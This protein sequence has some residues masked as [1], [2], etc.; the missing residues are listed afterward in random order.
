M[1][2]IAAVV[3]FS[4]FVMGCGT[5]FAGEV[6]RLALW[7]EMD[8]WLAGEGQGFIVPTV[9]TTDWVGFVSEGNRLRGLDTGHSFRY[10][11]DR[12]GSFYLGVILVDDPDGIESLKVTCKGREIGTIYGTD[13]NG[14]ALYSFS[15]VLKVKPGDALDF[16]CLTPVGCYRIYDLVFAKQ[17]IIPPLP[18][19]KFIET[20]C[21]EPGSVDVCWTTTGIVKTG[22]I[23]YQS[24]GSTSQSA[25]SQ[26]EGRNHRIRLVGLDPTA[27]Y[28]G[29]IV[30]MLR[31]EELASQPFTFRATPKKPASSQAFAIDLAIEEPTDTKRHAWPVTIGMPFSRGKLAQAA[32]LS[33][34]DPQGKRVPLQAST[35][36]IWDDGSVKWTTLDF[37]A[38]SGRLGAYR[39]ETQSGGTTETTDSNRL[40]TIK[41]SPEEW[42]LSTGA[43]SFTIA[44]KG[45][46]F[47]GRYGFD[48]NRDGMIG[49]AEVTTGSAESG[50]AIETGEGQVLY[51]AAPKVVDVREN[52][53]IRAVVECAGVMRGPN[54]GLGWHYLFRLTFWQGMPGMAVNVTLWN[55]DAEPQFRKIRR[56]SVNVPVAGGPNLRGAFQG[57]TLV[58]VPEGESMR[59][60]Q[61]QDN[62]YTRSCGTELEEGERA[63]GLVSMSQD[64]EVM[65]L[66]CRDFWQTYPSA[67]ELDTTSL[68]V[69]LLPALAP[70]TYSVQNADGWF[71][72]LYAWFEDGCYLMRAGQAT[73]H[74]FYLWFNANEN[75]EAVV[76]QAQWFTQPLLAQASS[77]YLCSTGSLGGGVFPRTPGVWDSYETF[78]DGGFDGLTQARESNRMYGWMNF[79]DWYGERGYNAGNNEYDLAW[80]VGLQWMRT[81]DRQYFLPGLEMA[82]HYA[83]VDTIRGAW[84]ENLPGVVWEHSFNHVGTQR[85]PDALG[86]DEH[87]RKY[88]SSEPGTFKGGMDPQGHIFEDGVWLYGLLTGDAFL[89]DTAERVCTRQ[90]D[91]LTPTFDFEIERGGGWPLINASGAYLFT[92]NPYYLNAARIMVQR[93]LERHDPEHGGWPH[94]PPLNETLGVPVVGGKAFATGILGFG[95][96]RY[97]EVE[98]RDRPEVER[99]LVNT[100]DW[101]MNESWEPGNGF[102]YITNAPN[103]V[104][105][106]HRGHECLMNADIIGFAYE[107]TGDK[108]YLEFWEEMMAGAFDSGLTGWGKGFSQGSRQTVFGL[109]R[110]QRAGITSCQPLKKD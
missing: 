105:K 68:R 43:T 16:T 49:A 67:L 100:A 97:L 103:F 81:G 12:E 24:T 31:G 5:V 98:P 15:Q 18:E 58:K 41:E 37:L 74:E 88:A 38:D 14:K 57:Q 46:A 48:K 91:F 66:L 93:C 21:T 59:L 22:W 36:S 26:A 94:V 42:E 55:G 108:K 8:A 76:Q 62:H 107:T 30:T 10:V 70:N 69:D 1:R 7:P 89:L 34:A 17:P 33:L 65:S 71:H 53:P 79:G 106:G 96:L 109:S 35:T 23:E 6:E 75:E 47:F 73:Q 4:L 78:F 95:L 13:E 110:A 90:A 54:G 40:L 60:F 32:D 85:S 29:R 27:E 56:V 20:W 64:A 86:F 44:K 80:C 9:E 50:L 92:G 19:F 25:I 63:M 102:K 61:D 82:R 72:R 77:E 39:L 87:A 51:C 28:S 99:M 101:L 11:F 45:A 84:T 104:G 3:G 2:R 52:G 83:T